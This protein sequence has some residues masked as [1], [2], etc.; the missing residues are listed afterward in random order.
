M[1]LGIGDVRAKSHCVRW[2]RVVKLAVRRSA[3]NFYSHGQSWNA[4][5]GS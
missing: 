2:S 3:F 1:R 4:K 5:T